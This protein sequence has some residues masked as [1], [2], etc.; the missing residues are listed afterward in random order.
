MTY[1]TTEQAIEPDRSILVVALHGKVHGV[2]RDTGEVRWVNDLGGW[3][4]RGHVALAVGYGIIIAAAETGGIHCLHYRTGTSR[5]RGD[6]QATGRATVL[7]E[8][9][10]IICAK[11]GYVDAYSPDGRLLWQQPLRGAGTGTAAIGYPDN[12]VQADAIGAQ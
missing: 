1:R 9:D 3:G 10:Q 6:T 4:S 5:W 8:A 2:D 7:I 11:G 12:V